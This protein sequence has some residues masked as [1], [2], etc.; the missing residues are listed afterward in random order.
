MRS[1]PSFAALLASSMLASAATGDGDGEFSIIG[2]P[3]TQKYSESFPQVFM[4]QTDWV[5]NQL[6]TLDIRFVTHYGDIVDNADVD[7][8]WLNA[9]EAMRVLDA[10]SVPQ[11]VTSGNHDITPSGAPG[12]PY[13][14]QN[15]LN[16][17]G[18]SRY[19]G[20]PYFQNASPSGMSTWQLFDGGDREFIG[21]SVECETP[22]AELAWAQG[23]LDRHRDKSVVF[24]TH[25]YMQ[26]AEDYTAG[27][28]VVP[29]GRFPEIWYAFE[30]QYHPAGIRANDL[31]DW[32][33]RRQPNIFLVNCGHFHEEYRQTSTNVAGMPVREVLA[34]YQDDPNGGDGWLRIM[35]F[36]VPGERVEFQT[37]SP[38]LDEYRFTDES[39]FSYVVE[40]DRY[41]TLDGFAAFQDG[42]NGYGGTRDTWVNE[43]D[44]DRSYGQDDTETSDDDTANS[45]FSDYRGQGLVRFDGIFSETPSE[46]TIPPGATIFSAI[47]TIDIA[48][49]VDTPFFDPFFRVHPVLVPWE[50]D[51]TW[52]SLDDGLSVGTDLGSAIAEFSGDN[53]DNGDTMRRIDVTG[54]VQAWS[55]GQPNYGVAILPEII[56]GNDDGI[57]IWT[58]EFANPLLRPRLE[59]TYEAI[60]VAPTA[61][62]NG[63][64]FVDG[65]DLGM[66]FSMWGA[67]PGCPGD[68]NLDGVVDGADFG[69]LFAAWGPV[70]P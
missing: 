18:P 16:Y 22:L 19:V 62:L 45:I 42:I 33:I 41:R 6:E 8:E 51:S 50:E 3:D 37:Y 70:S 23:V 49:D 46:G 7:G 44:P 61:D 39:L 58:R 32:F 10:T 36:D 1:R 27:V 15:Y 11:G 4:S 66:L 34:D 47:I 25:R 60:E 43:D 63:D 59:I 13:T 52:N 69:T 17:F 20:R 12:Q 14:P 5:A 53:A 48:D 68:L 38:Y 9:D 30:R 2:L 56:D 64:G 57:R 54:L 24:T 40:F 67:C 35:D 55:D 29:S 28:P 21:L 26:D 65:A 31:F